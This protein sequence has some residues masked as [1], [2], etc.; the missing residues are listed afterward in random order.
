MI[1][2]II[3]LAA[4]FALPLTVDAKTVKST[5]NPVSVA[6][7][8]EIVPLVKNSDMQISAVVQDLGGSTDLSSTQNVFLT[9]YVKGE[10]FNV[11]ATFLVSDVIEF[12]SASATSPTT[13][14]VVATYYD[15]SARLFDRTYK[16]DAAKAIADM[17]AVDC[18]GD[19]D[20]DAAEKFASTVEVTFDK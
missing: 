14:E 17:K 11:E 12:K 7:V 13:F 3:V 4:V 10:M 1:K 20:C 9:M 18:G 19:F 6:R 5:K 16:I 2:S 15:G 8:V